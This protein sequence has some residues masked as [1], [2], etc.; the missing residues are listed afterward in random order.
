ML[1]ILLFPQNNF[2]AAE[3]DE[4]WN[5]NFY[6]SVKENIDHWPITSWILYWIN[7]K[8]FILIQ[9]KSFRFELSQGAVEVFRA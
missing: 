6:G 1:W 5:G 3:F 2:T 9:K 7:L 8:M 4:I